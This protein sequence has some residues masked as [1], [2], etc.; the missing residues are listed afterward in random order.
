MGGRSEEKHSVTVGRP[1]AAGGVE[2]KFS[3]G[4][5][6]LLPFLLK[7]GRTRPDERE[8]EGGKRGIS[9]CNCKARARPPKTGTI[10][11]ALRRCQIMQ[12]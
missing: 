12:D 10:N 6:F 7:S 9:P 5:T 1:P 11:E 2:Y 3:L 4:E 8:R